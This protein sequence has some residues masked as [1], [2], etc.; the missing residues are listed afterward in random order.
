MQQPLFWAQPQA[1]T[2]SGTIL[3]LHRLLASRSIFE[4]SLHGLI[5]SAQKLVGQKEQLFHVMESLFRQIGK[6][7]ALHSRILKSKKLTEQ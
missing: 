7:E 3:C 6:P 5:G 1:T 2:L 4:D